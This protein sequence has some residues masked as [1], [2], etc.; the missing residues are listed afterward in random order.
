[1]RWSP[2]K[3]Q[4][5]IFPFRAELTTGGGGAVREFG[6]F[7]EGPKL[8]FSS[9]LYGGANSHIP[10]LSVNMPEVSSGAELR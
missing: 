7:F 3:S 6:A 2:S 5:Q 9:I 8:H 1:M 10:A 4:S